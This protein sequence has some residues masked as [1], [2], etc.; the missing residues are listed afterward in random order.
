MVFTVKLKAVKEVVLPEVTDEFARCKNGSVY[1]CPKELKDDI[2]RE[3]TDA[4][5]REALDKLKDELIAKLIGRQTGSS[6][7]ILLAD[8]RRSI[9]QD[10]TQNLAYQDSRLK[11]YLGNKSSPMKSGLMA[12]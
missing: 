11:N 9:E 7:E 6:T 4:K 1:D 12:K 10:M 3:L 8:Q 5:E 2:K